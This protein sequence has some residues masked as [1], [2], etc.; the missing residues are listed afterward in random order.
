M[1]NHHKVGYRP[2]TVELG[3]APRIVQFRFDVY[4]T[5]GN[6][7]IDQIFTIHLIPVDDKP[8]E[9]TF[10]VRTVMRREIDILL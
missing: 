4:D 3:S 10:E 9:I 8:P 5:T 1:V 7:I 2:P 6:A